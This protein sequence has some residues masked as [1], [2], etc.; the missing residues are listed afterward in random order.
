MT[1]APDMKTPRPTRLALALFL[2]SGLGACSSVE[3]LLAGDK[4]DYRSSASN[5]TKGLEVPPDLTQLAKENRYQLPGGVVSAAATSGG[6]T[7]SALK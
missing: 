5:Q 7:V 2:A 3:N 1:S 4:V 6:T